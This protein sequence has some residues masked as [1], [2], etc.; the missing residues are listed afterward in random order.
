MR[1]MAHDRAMAAM[2]HTQA[3]Q[4]SSQQVAGQSALQAQAAE[5]QPQAA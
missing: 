1:Q 3:L 5:Q 2:Q 4:Q